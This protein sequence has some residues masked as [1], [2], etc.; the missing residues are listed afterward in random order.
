MLVMRGH[1][2]KTS[3]L[4]KL[5]LCVCRNGGRQLSSRGQ[6]SSNNNDGT[7]PR[8]LTVTGEGIKYEEHIYE[9][10]LHLK[11]CEAYSDTEPMYKVPRPVSCDEDDMRGDP[12]ANEVGYEII[13][14]PT[15]GNRKSTKSS[16]GRNRESPHDLGT[17]LA[18]GSVYELMQHPS[19]LGKGSTLS[20]PTT[21]PTPYLKPVG[22]SDRHGIAAGFDLLQQTSDKHDAANSPQ[23]KGILEGSTYN[24]A[25]VAPVE[26]KKIL[27][28]SNSFASAGNH[29]PTEYV[30]MKSATLKH[31]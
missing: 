13:P 8:G 21:S 25:N 11:S 23:D 4:L 7:L 6:S 27:K 19:S 24:Y 17:E 1:P 28:T 9:D 31:Q 18:S 22:I 20:L 15:L 16:D 26:A 30:V 2:L 10:P 3:Y 29:E 5:S 12:C 14:L